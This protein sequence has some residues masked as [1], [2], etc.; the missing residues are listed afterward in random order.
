MLRAV[1]IQE[2][3]RH[4]DAGQGRPAFRVKLCC[5][6]IVLQ[7]GVFISIL[8]DP[9][10]WDMSYS[11]IS[12][13]AALRYAFRTTKVFIPAGMSIGSIYQRSWNESGVVRLD[14]N[15]DVD[16]RSRMK[17]DMRPGHTETVLEKE[18]REDSKLVG[19]E[20]EGSLKNEASGI[21]Q[22]ADEGVEAQQ[23]SEHVHEE[24]ADESLLLL[25]ESSQGTVGEAEED[26][27]MNAEEVMS[28]QQTPE[29][30]ME[31]LAKSLKI[32]LKRD[33]SKTH[34]GLCTRVVS[35][36]ELMEVK[37]ILLQSIT[38]MPRWSLRSI[39]LTLY[40]G[41][42]HENITLAREVVSAFRTPRSIQVV[43]VEAETPLAVV[44]LTVD[45][46][47]DFFVYVSPHGEFSD[48][49]WA[50]TS[51]HSMELRMP[52]GTAF[53]NISNTDRGI[54]GLFFNAK[55]F[56]A[57]LHGMFHSTLLRQI[58]PRAIAEELRS[59]YGLDALAI[60]RPFYSNTKSEQKPWK[61]LSSMSE[62]VD[63]AFL[64]AKKT[65]TSFNAIRGVAEKGMGAYK[66]WSDKQLR[67]FQLQTLEQITGS[68]SPE[69]VK[70]PT[71]VLLVLTVSSNNHTVWQVEKLMR[72]FAETQKRQLKEYNSS[73]T[74]KFLI[75]FYQ[76][77]TALW[78]K[79]LKRWSSMVHGQ[80]LGLTCKIRK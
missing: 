35:V 46:G 34:I 58:Q 5:L 7:L 72:F 65:L 3:R 45:L 25:N 18:A 32:N 78:D 27:A 13:H 53:V 26:V 41:V 48:P 23:R 4:S 10:T 66:S 73:D 80:R 57:I 62:S 22:E 77:K 75:N 12:P 50:I 60:R 71:N 42:P 64:Y 76:P 37:D 59:L 61:V 36:G 33:P 49:D 20:T 28:S 63:K 43:A 6:L 19:M 54:E 47:E 21:G 69:E 2:K 51:L 24:A 17:L 40:V 55:M 29:E 1:E 74:V 9:T 30:S 56:E 31:A 15:G 79:I 39:A 67:S 52:R 14:D 70:K 68:M 38:S 44:Q 8:I 16:H 11:D